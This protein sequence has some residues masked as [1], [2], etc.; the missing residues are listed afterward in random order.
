MSSAEYQAVYMCQVICFTTWR[1]LLE[2]RSVSSHHIV[3]SIQNGDKFLRMP[4]D[5]GNGEE[6]IPLILITADV[7]FPEDTFVCM[8]AK[9]LAFASLYGA[10]AVC[11]LASSLL[12]EPFK[13]E[14]LRIRLAWRLLSTLEVNSSVW[15]LLIKVLLFLRGISKGDVMIS[16]VSEMPGVIMFACPVDNAN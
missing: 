14:R 8:Y 16:Q 15:F 13:H 3:N 12:K 6:T 1:M 11:V 7:M 9:A 2:G 10:E 4:G 5:S